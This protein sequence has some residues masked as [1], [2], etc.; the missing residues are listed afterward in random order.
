MKAAFGRHLL[1]VLSSTPGAGRET[2]RD[3]EVT[4][5]DACAVGGADG[6]A[7]VAADGAADGA[8]CSRCTAASA[9]AGP[10]QVDPRC[11]TTGR[12]K[13]MRAGRRP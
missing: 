13:G 10:A 6:A 12:A 8:A 5:E 11:T 1:H 7:D 3:D 9:G 4:D 2:S